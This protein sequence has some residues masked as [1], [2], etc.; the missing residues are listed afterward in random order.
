MKSILRKNKETIVAFTLSCIVLTIGIIFH[1][2]YIETYYS[3][4]VYGV[5]IASFSV[6]TLSKNKW[7]KDILW[8]LCSI[9]FYCLLA[10]LFWEYQDKPWSS[11]PED[12][13]C[14]GRC[15]GWFSFENPLNYWGIVLGG[16]ISG[17]FG[18]LIRI[19]RYYAWNRMDK[20]EF[21]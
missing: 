3:Y 2:G 10:K 9:A 14:D 7:Y 11:R 16:T 1:T 12:G 13:S 19:I 4:F 8:I 6:V 15:Y 17:L 21:L 5:S 18:S 20:S